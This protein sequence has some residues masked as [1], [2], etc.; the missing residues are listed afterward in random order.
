M[1]IQKRMKMDEKRDIVWDD[2]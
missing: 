2:S 1:P